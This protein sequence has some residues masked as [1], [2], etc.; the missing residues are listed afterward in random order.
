M[1]DGWKE[2]DGKVQ[3]HILALVEEVMPGIIKG[4]ALGV[5]EPKVNL[6]G[7]VWDLEGAIVFFEE[8]IP[9][10]VDRQISQIGVITVDELLVEI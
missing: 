9:L 8:E 7:G 6:E 4:E 1:E 3:V 5:M 2:A 10:E